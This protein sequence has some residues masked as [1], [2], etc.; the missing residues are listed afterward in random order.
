[1]TNPDEGPQPKNDCPVNIIH[2]EGSDLIKTVDICPP[3]E[4]GVPKTGC[5]P[6]DWNPSPGGPRPEPEPKP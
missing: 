2:L 1:M 3:D 5:T 6:E 4:S